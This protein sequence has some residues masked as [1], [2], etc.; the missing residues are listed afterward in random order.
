M[1]ELEGNEVIGTSIA[2]STAELL[3]D[4]TKLDKAYNSNEL[5]NGIENGSIR[6]GPKTV[7]IF[8]EAA[9][10]DTP[11]HERLAELTEQAGSKFFGVGDPAQLSAIGAGGIY[12]ELLGRAPTAELKKVIRANH[13]WESKAWE[14]VRN[15]EPGPALAAYQAHDRMHI[16]DTRV[17][18]TVA[19]VEHWDKVRK[20]LPG[21]EAVMITDATNLERDQVNAM[22]QERRIQ[23]GEL[24]AHEV[25]L[26][27][28]PYGLRAGDEVIF[29][30]Q[31]HGRGQP[32]VKNGIS[33]TVIDTSRN[34]EE[35]LLTL[36][37]K[38]E[39][40]REVHVDTSEF[41]DLSL[42]YAVH[43]VKAQGITAERS[44]IMTGGW[45]TDREH[46]YTELTRAREETQIYVSREDLG[47]Q[48]FDIGAM[49]RLAER[50]QRSRAQ[51]AS[52]TKRLADRTTSITKRLADRTTE[53]H[54]TAQPHPTPE[55]D[56]EL[57]RTND[58]V[59]DTPQQIEHIERQ[60]LLMRDQGV[61]EATIVKEI[62][63]EHSN[64]DATGTRTTQDKR[65][66]E[67]EIAEI[68]EKQRQRQLDWDRQAQLDRDRHP[69]HDRDINRPRDTDRD[70]Q[71]ETQHTPER[72]EEP[73]I[74]LREVDLRDLFQP[75]RDRQR[76]WEGSI[77]QD[78]QVN[79]ADKADH[80]DRD[81]GQPQ[82]AGRDNDPATDR[83]PHID[84]PQETARDPWV[85]QAIQEERDRQHAWEQG[86]D[87]D[88]DN[89]RGFE[90]E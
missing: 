58:R 23:A 12:K 39:E 19:M 45:Q 82:D 37:T 68:L 41:S 64:P 57:E 90:I 16:H 67:R 43:I 55:R 34:E 63:Q 22:A 17:Q 20:T 10:A 66:Y 30:A 50:M 5:I 28:K 86:I 38:Q 77:D 52:I 47:E 48:G 80:H 13:A 70:E 24:G 81:I 8:D 26:P 11:R 40:P 2:A 54:R 6:I 62:A 27:G 49:E 61:D 29:T 88:R 87:P 36:R 18:A 59:I 35:N 15:G 71:R 69:D 74:E 79:Q 85:E 1:E 31:F 78:H 56:P 33:A 9:M 7:V 3:K 89:D 32:S 44:G 14:Q 75:Q 60:A 84:Q 4:T 21:N 42:R 46:I 65:R 25:E 73:D 53:R 76:D 83:D 51:E 72:G